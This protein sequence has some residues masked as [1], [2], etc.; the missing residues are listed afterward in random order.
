MKDLIF[1]KK[2]AHKTYKTFGEVTNYDRFSLLLY[3]CKI[4]TEIRYKE[5]IES[6][7]DSI[8]SDLKFFLK[9]INDSKIK[10]GQ[11]YSMHMSG[12]NCNDPL[13]I[14]DMYRQYFSQVYKTSVAKVSNI[15]YK[16]TVDL[17]RVAIQP[18]EVSR[19]LNSLK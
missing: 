9:F 12:K 1:Q 14:A 15:C 10:K 4:E 3:R 13:E 18:D 16:Q 6:V 8:R 11:P 19:E 5:F 7:E 17:K 2:A